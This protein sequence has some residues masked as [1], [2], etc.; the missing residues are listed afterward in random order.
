MHVKD[1]FAKPVK[2]IMCDDM[3]ETPIFNLKFKTDEEHLIYGNEYY[4][5][6]SSTKLQGQIDA[7]NDNSFSQTHRNGPQKLDA[8]FAL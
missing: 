3:V 7:T 2:H 6:M 5:T 1:P 8:N 4:F